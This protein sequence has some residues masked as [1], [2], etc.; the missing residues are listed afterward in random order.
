M[1]VFDLPNMEG[2][3]EYGGS[4]I[5][6]VD[7]GVS[8]VVRSGTFTLNPGESLVP[9]RHDSDEVFYVIR[10]TITVASGDHS[11]IHTVRPGQML[12]IPAQTVHLSSN[13]G[14]EPV[15]IFWCYRV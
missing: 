7:E 3:K 10:G 14:D 8:S 1:R 15:E 4:V 12:H 2:T 11:E 5:I 13:R 9:D 6:A